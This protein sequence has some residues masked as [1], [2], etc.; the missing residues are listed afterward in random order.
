VKRLT[1]QPNA[2]PNADAGAVQN[3]KLSVVEEALY[4]TKNQ[5]SQ[6]PLNFPIR[7]NN[8]LAALGGVVSQAEAAPNEQ[9][10]AVYDELAAQINAQLSKLSQVL[11]TDVPAFNQMVR[12][13]NIPAI[14]VKPQ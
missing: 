13:Q 7:L 5:S 1:G 11:K 12:D 6:D 8:K 4:Q 9:S 10:Y 3:K 14:V 2:K